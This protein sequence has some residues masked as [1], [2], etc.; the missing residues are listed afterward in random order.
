MSGLELGV[1]LLGAFVLGAFAAG[2]SIYLYA[3]HVFRSKLGL[4]AGQLT[5]SAATIPPPDS[6]VG[7]TGRP[8]E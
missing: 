3:R 4:L 7:S 2:L 8:S 1:E 6:S 5:G